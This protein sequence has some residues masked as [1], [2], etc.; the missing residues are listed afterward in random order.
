MCSHV[1][2][3]GSPYSRFQRAIRS[4]NLALIHATAAELP[5][6]PLPDALTILLRPRRKHEERFDAAAVR[7]AGR[8]ATEAPGLELDELA[9]ALQSLNALP[10]KHAQHSLLALATRA[11]RPA[12]APA[13]PVAKRRSQQPGPR[14]R[15]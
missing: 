6:V 8:L 4:G 7:W 1:T 10:D 5:Y 11:R 15:S 12:G 3:D 9:G 2:S 13:P 14:W